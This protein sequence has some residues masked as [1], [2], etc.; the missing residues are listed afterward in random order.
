MSPLRHCVEDLSLL[1]DELK[2]SDND[3][4]RAQKTLDEIER[5]KRGFA[6]PW[7]QPQHTACTHAKTGYRKTVSMRMPIYY[8]P[9]NQTKVG[10]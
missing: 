7:A 6:N 3:L 5:Q 9:I 1:V 4:T 8:G 2:K 10:L